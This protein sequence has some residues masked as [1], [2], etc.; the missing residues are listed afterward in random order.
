MTE[1]R[2]LDRGWH[3]SVP[4]F[5]TPSVSPD[6]HMVFTR[7]VYCPSMPYGI[8]SHSPSILIVSMFMTMFTSSRTATLRHWT[9][10]KM[11]DHNLKQD[12]VIQAVVATVPGSSHWHISRGEPS[13]RPAVHSGL[14]MDPKGR[15]RSCSQKCTIYAWHILCR[16]PFLLSGTPLPAH[17]S[18][19]QEHRCRGYVGVL[20]TG[21][22]RAVVDVQPLY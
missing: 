9:L 3:A 11:P 4:A 14:C 1:A 18:G 8:T 13:H 15:K 2:G 22:D 7:N 21:S 6:I 10:R 20:S 12:N 5:H 17:V 19:S 16:S